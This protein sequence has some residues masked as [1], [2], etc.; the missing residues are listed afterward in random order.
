MKGGRSQRGDSYSLIVVQVSVMCTHIYIYTHMHMYI[1]DVYIYIFLS[2]QHLDFHQHFKQDKI[3]F[4][5]IISNLNP[6]SGVQ[7]LIALP[8]V[9][10]ILDLTLELTGSNPGDIYCSS[11]AFLIPLHLAAGRHLLLKHANCSP[12]RDFQG[13]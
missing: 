11:P 2:V 13:S 8:T 7:A 3:K 10:V 12:F 6:G 4:I 5:S 9:K 1:L